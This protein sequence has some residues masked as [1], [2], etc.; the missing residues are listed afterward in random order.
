MTCFSHL[1]VAEDDRVILSSGL[2]RR[3]IALL[4]PLLL[5]HAPW[6]EQP[7]VVSD[8][9]DTWIPPLPDLQP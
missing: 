3:C 7:Q 5:L 1:D 9:T 8:L 4:A 2:K 6:E